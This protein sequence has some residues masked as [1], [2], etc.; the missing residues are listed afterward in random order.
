[1]TVYESKDGAQLDQGHFLRTLGFDLPDAAEDLQSL[2]ITG[3]VQSDDF[4]IGGDQGKIDLKSFPAKDG[5]R[6]AIFVST[7]RDIEL[8]VDNVSVQPANLRVKLTEKGKDKAGAKRNWS[9]EV[10]V[11]PNQLFGTIPED[12]A[13]ILRTKATPPRLIRIPLVGHAIQG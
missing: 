6:K 4:L 2:I 3:N 7:K 12:S 10:E 13:V 1:V 11:P 5:K 9:L 8:D